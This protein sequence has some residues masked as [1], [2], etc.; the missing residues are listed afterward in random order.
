MFL[1]LH[2]HQNVAVVGEPVVFPK[3]YFYLFLL[4]FFFCVCGVG[5]ELGDLGERGS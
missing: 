3:F 1:N 2:Q 4:Y 5:G